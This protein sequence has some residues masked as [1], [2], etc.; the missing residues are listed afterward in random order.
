MV[1]ARPAAESTV[2]TEALHAALRPALHPALHP[3]LLMALLPA[4]LLASAL[5]A[6]LILRHLLLAPWMEEVLF[7]WGLQDRLASAR[8]PWLHRHAPTLTAAAFAA[9]HALLAP[10]TLPLA[11]ALSTALPAWW[12]GRDYRRHRSLLRCV[13]WHA[14]FNAVWLLGSPLLLSFPPLLT[15]R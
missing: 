5:P 8:A 1:P 7:R 13:A 12:I 2:P 6:P 14:G 15:T 10:P 11:L 4:L 3:A 9:A